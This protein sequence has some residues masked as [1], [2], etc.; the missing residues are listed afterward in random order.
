MLQSPPTDSFI[1]YLQNC[2]QLDEA[3]LPQRGEWANAGNTLGMIALRLDA[4]TVEQ[5]D[6]ILARQ[7][8]LEEGEELN[9]QQKKERGLLFG[10]LAERMGFLTDSEMG[11]LLQIQK[12]NRNLELG[13]KLVLNGTIDAQ[14][15][16]SHLSEFLAE[17]KFAVGS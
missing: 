8:S 10:Q 14:T 4:L 15:L 12:I 17:S 2:L 16:V 1:D 5:V 7:E 9:F 11:R 13:A 6:E 3:E